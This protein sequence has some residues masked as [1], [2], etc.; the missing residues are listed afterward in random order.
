MAVGP[1]RRALLGVSLA[2]V[3]AA[4]ALAQAERL[5]PLVSVA[6]LQEQ[7]ASLAASRDTRPEVKAFA[8]EMSAWR[9]GQMER[10]RPLMQARGVTRPELVAEHEAAWEGLERLDYLALTRRYAEIQVQAL[11]W[12]I[13]AYEEVSRGGDQA[14]ASLAGETLPEL[15][16]LMEGARRAQAAAGP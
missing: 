7:A 5:R 6:V 16:R 9:K 2:A 8:T 1:S 12:E 4:P 10:L 3:A 11:E 13:R 14:L 15:R